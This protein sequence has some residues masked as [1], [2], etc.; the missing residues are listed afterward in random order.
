[1][2]LILAHRGASR[3]APENT[4]AAFAAAV[5]L[6]ADGVEL[7]VHRSADDELIV[8][9]DAT[10][11]DAVIGELTHAEL[12]ARLPDVPTLAEVLD[13][14]SGRLVNIEIKNLP[15]QPG[16][17][18]HERVAARVVELLR[19]RSSDRVVVSS[20]HLPSIDR[21][22]ALDPAVETAYL[23]AAGDIDDAIPV[24][25]EHGHTGLHPAAGMLDD[26]RARDVVARAHDAGLRVRAWTVND[27]LDILRLA[28]TAI[29]AIITDVPDVAI[30][31]LRERRS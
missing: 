29:D 20:F 13:A 1:V 17:D 10:I 4:L 27:P 3:L 23:V 21:V 24:A 7:D 14:C 6:G 22:H 9:H 8:R 26:R 2:T 28:A 5:R 18:R 30:D 11:G 25:R 12:L 31:V 15:H 19:A 16:F